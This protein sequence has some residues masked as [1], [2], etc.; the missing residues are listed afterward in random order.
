MAE[1]DQ[2]A[3]VVSSVLRDGYS[4]S[5]PTSSRDLL[6]HL[7][8]TK[9]ATGSTSL[10]LTDLPR[11]DAV[12][13]NLAGQWEHGTITIRR[14]SDVL[15]IMGVQLGNTRND[16]SNPRKR[17]RPVDEEADSAAGDDNDERSS[18]SISRSPPPSRTPLGSLSKE[19]REVYA[20][21]QR[22]TAKGR[23][24]AE[25]VRVRCRCWSMTDC[26]CCTVVSLAAALLQPHL[27]VRHKGRMLQGA[28]RSRQ[29]Y[30]SHVP[31]LRPRAL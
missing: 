24:L 2:L 13:E 25:R 28:S 6:L 16:A 17:K 7:I 18:R 10:R 22:S 29:V 4:L 27:L 20:L 15:T 9:T 31:Y 14:D 1:D 21:L 12:L 11:L 23:L 19:L 8:S 26:T 30:A 3:V 5:V